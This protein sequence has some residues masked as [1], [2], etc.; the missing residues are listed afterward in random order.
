VPRTCHRANLFTTTAP[1]V[2]CVHRPTLDQPHQP[3][4]VTSIECTTRGATGEDSTRNRDRSC[5]SSR[6]GHTRLQA[7]SRTRQT[8]TSSLEGWSGFDITFNLTS[9]ELRNRFQRQGD[10]TSHSRISEYRRKTSRTRFNTIPQEPVINHH[11]SP[12][13]TTATPN[14]RM[15]AFHPKLHAG[16][17]G[18]SQ[19]TGASSSLSA[20]I[21]LDQDPNQN[22]T[23]N[24]NQ[25]TQTANVAYTNLDVLSGKVL[26]RTA[27]SADISSIVVKLEGESRS[28][29]MTPPG[30]NGERSRAVVE[31]HKVRLGLLTCT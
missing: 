22:P 1:C 28:R 25:A 12:K 9:G 11:R 27:K 13:C 8:T 7:P 16:G 23:S 26:V 30:P 10:T 24:Q 14:N 17:G 19:W 31:Y 15:S 5:S 18:L 3:R 20:S 21:V 2:I 6:P 29:L 4:Q